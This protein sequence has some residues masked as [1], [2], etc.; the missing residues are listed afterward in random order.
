MPSVE[1]PAPRPDDPAFEL[2]RLRSELQL[3]QARITE[4]EQQLA[5]RPAGRSRKR[6]VAAD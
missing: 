3:A 4:L 1:L 2:I 5:A 6:P